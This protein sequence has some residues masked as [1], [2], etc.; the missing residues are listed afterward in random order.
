MRQNGISVV[1][2]RKHKATTDSNHKFNIAPNLLDRNFTADGPNRKWACDITY[3]WTREGWLYLAVILDLHSR[4][5][6]GWAVSNAQRIAGPTVI[7]DI[8]RVAP[9]RAN[10]SG[11]VKVIAFSST[12]NP[13][14]FLIVCVIAILTA[15]DSW[16]CIN[17]HLESRLKGKLHTGLSGCC[18]HD[19]R[20]SGSAIEK[21][22][23]LN[24]NNLIEYPSG[25]GANQIAADNKPSSNKKLRFSGKIITVLN[26]ERRSALFKQVVTLCIYQVKIV[27][28]LI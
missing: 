8:V 17:T 14:A 18:G 28:D 6:I 24:S 4:R 19:T 26:L 1:R 13:S 10:A 15:C 21:S 27:L 20:P 3:I 11:S 5:V 12:L 2:T 22:L 25:E 16:C 7:P 23:F 9:N